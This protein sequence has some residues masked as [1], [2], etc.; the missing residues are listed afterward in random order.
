MTTMYIDFSLESKERGINLDEYFVGKITKIEKGMPFG[1]KGTVADT[2]EWQLITNKMFC[3]DTNDILN[4]FYIQFSKNRQEII[5]EIKS[6]NAK[7]YL[8]IVINVN[9]EKHDEFSIT[10]APEMIAFLNELNAEFAID[11]IYQ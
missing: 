2:Y 4:D 9:K 5:K 8:Y 10:L 7:V 6:T 1:K 11:G 3:I